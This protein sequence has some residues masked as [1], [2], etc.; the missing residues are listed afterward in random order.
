MEQSY[1]RG[2]ARLMLRWPERRDNLRHKAVHDR[3]FRDLCQAY[4][5]AWTAVDYWSNSSATVGPERAQEYRSLAKETE[6]DILQ[7]LSCG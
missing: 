2:L 6:D 4:E 3:H 7:A 5:E 1:R